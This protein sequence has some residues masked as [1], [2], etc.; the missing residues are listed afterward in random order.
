[1]RTS[2][3]HFCPVPV[4]IARIID[5]G[6]K[7]FVRIDDLNGQQDVRKA[8]IWPPHILC[9]SDGG[10]RSGVGKFVRTISAFEMVVVSAP[11]C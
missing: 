2:H 4:A 3:S 8:S 1:M 6:I 7:G 5:R 10:N 9:R 11:Y